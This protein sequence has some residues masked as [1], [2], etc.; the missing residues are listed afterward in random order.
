[1]AHFEP[2]HQDLRCLQFS[3]FRLWYLKEFKNNM[4]ITRSIAYYL[5]IVGVIGWCDG[6]G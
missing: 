1:M 6:A 3:Y 5:P 4:L 2:P